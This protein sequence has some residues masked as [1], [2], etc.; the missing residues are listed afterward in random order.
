MCDTMVVLPHCSGDGSLLF[1]KNSDR[2]P[3]EPH[4]IVRVPQRKIEAGEKIHCTY[5]SIDNSGNSG[6][7]TNEAILFKPSWI[8]GAEMGVN[9][10]GLVIGNEAVFTREKIEDKALL[11]MDILRLVLEL[12]SSAKEALDYI[13]ELTEKYGQGGKAGYT[14]N[15]KYHNSYI[16]ADQSEAYILETAGRQWVYEKVTDIRSISNTLSI[17]DCYDGCSSKLV[18]NAL[19][20]GWCRSREEFD[21]KKCYESKVHSFFTKGDT[22]RNASE[23]YLRAKLGSLSVEDMKEILRS[24]GIRKD[25]AGF[26][27]GSMECICMHAGGGLIT[28]QTTGSFVV[29]LKNG[30]VDIWATGSSIPCISVFKPIW[31]TTLIS[32]EKSEEPE[33]FWKQVEE[34][35]RRI[36]DGSIREIDSFIQKRDQ[37]EKELFI[38]ASGA[39]SHEERAKVTEYAFNREKSL[40]AELISASSGTQHKRK[41]GFCYKSYWERQ[42]RLFRSIR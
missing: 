16:I 14:Q 39:I 7:Y 32:G 4:I 11:G 9:D 10:K 28:S 22:R 20:K 33:A 24:H 38:L 13:A 41:C 34:V 42:N 2:E 21:F 36:L 25:V 23:G 26:R 29:R 35:H 15:L 6:K 12:C 3:N 17:R 18:E 31:F 30:E 27:T 37:L 19:S 8:W 1:A 5:I 40:L